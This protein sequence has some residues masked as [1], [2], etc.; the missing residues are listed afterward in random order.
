LQNKKGKESMG[1]PK[2]YDLTDRLLDFTVR[3]IKLVNALPKSAVGK[4][5]SG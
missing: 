1:I 3:I 5:I 2:K 4:Q